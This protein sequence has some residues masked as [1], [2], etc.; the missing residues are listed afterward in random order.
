MELTA[1]IKTAEIELETPVAQPPSAAADDSPWRPTP[2]AEVRKP[3]MAAGKHQDAVIQ[4]LEQ[5]LAELARWDR[6]RGFHR[7][8]A[9][10]SREQEDDAT[11]P[12]NR[13]VASELEARW[14]KALTRVTEVEAKIAVHDAALP[15]PP[16]DATSLAS[17]A[18]ELKAVWAAPTTDMRLKKRIVGRGHSGGSRRPQ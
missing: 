12:A 15:P 2:V 4:A 14:N 8:I 9:Q 17:L 5:L 16:A 3:L 10:L 13:L 1:A 11:D 7:D 6:F 18:S